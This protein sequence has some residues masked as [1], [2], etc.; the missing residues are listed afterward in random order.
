M[1]VGAS[2]R[3]SRLVALRRCG[4]VCP[5]PGRRRRAK[6]GGGG[7]CGW[8][9]GLQ[10]IRRQEEPRTLPA[11]SAVLSQ[12]VRR[13]QKLFCPHQGPGAIAASLPQHKKALT[14]RPLATY[15]ATLP[16][17]GGLTAEAGS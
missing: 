9:R 6:E 5:Q 2:R 10:G 17:P 11:A 3:L 8:C 7:G 12:Q 16:Q 1:G 15:K 14:Q 13:Q 4:A